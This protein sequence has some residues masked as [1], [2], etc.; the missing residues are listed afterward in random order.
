MYFNFMAA[1]TIRS[2]LELKKIKSFTVS[3][4]PPSTYAVSSCGT[5]A[6]LSGYLEM[7]FLNSLCS[8]NYRV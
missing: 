6:V 1:V 2:D 7:L 8:I 4:I 3:T 5:I